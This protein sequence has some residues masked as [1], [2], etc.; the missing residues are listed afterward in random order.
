MRGAVKRCSVVDLCNYL[1]IIL[2]QPSSLSVASIINKCINI[3]HVVSLKADSGASKNFIREQDAHQLLDVKKLLNQPSAKLPDNS[4]MRPTA[5]GLLPF[6]KILSS[7]ARDSI[8]YPNLK[9][10]FSVVHWATL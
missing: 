6:S 8:I 9:K 7:L 4:V 3:V 1:K 10:C 5:H 2:S